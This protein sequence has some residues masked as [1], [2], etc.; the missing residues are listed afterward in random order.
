MKI[1][2]TDQDIRTLL[3]SGYY[4]VP[5]FQRPYSW[6]RENIQEFWT[7][8]VTDSPT[9]YFIGSMVVYKESNQRFGIVDGQQRLTTITIFLAVL[10]NQLAAAEHADLAAGLQSLIERKN[11]DNREEFVLST[12][13]SYPFF[14]HKIQ[15][16]EGAEIKVQDLQEEITIRGAFEQLTELV[17][18]ECTE[19]KGSAAGDAEKA[20]KAI[21]ERLSAIRDA[22]LNLK[23][24]LIKLD[25]ED[26]AYMIFE[27]LNT[28][29]K[30]LSLKD[31]V[32]NQLTRTIRVRN[33]DADEVKVK[34]KQI[35]ETIEEAPGDLSTD[36]FILHEW[37]SKFEYL[38]AKRLFRVLR[39]RVTTDEEARRYL[40][41]LVTDATL[42]RE[43]Q[44]PQFGVWK[45][46]DERIR[47]ALG[48]LLLFRVSQPAPCVLSLLREYKSRKRLR[49]RQAESALVAI[50]HFHF[51]FT[52]ITSQRSSGGIATMYA[53]LA[54]RVFECK[55]SEEISKVLSDLAGK[56]KVRKP[57]L[58]QFKASFKELIFTDVHSKERK[59]VRYVLSRLYAHENAALALDFDQM[60]IEHILPQSKI[61]SGDHTHAEVGQLG[62]LLL[63]SADLNGKLKNRAF[64]EKKRILKEW[65]YP[66]PPEIEKAATWGPAEIEAR[67]DLLATDAYK[68]VWKV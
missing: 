44:D 4:R 26:D 60:T 63:V 48:A 15:K 8:I 65:G 2:S 55:D 14:Q 49:K 61:E 25:N 42:Y 18:Q 16:W 54:R 41:D 24:I 1:E 13:T 21:R 46:E 20:K 36:T 5:R 51:I 64:E 11:I 10:R 37:L 33:Q 47:G 34:W 52:A 59:L 62:N 28:R 7:D 32:K 67:T 68:D 27:T 17:L 38:A 6:D 29:G 12:E 58:D 30:D 50:E 57:S 35:L 43:M 45:K 3:S 40:A 31:L 66:I 9:D 19:A 39:K 22:I 56:L 23:I 53:S